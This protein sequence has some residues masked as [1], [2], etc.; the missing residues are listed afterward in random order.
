MKR[1]PALLLWFQLAGTGFI[2]V[3]LI[4]MVI[5]CMQVQSL[6]KGVGQV[7]FKC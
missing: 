6:R 4:S 2:V 1:A 3:Y 7:L 5:G